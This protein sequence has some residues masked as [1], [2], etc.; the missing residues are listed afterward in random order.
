MPYGYSPFDCRKVL[1]IVCPECPR[2]NHN[3]NVT[4]VLGIVADMDLCSPGA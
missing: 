1:R 3:V 4:Q 2:V